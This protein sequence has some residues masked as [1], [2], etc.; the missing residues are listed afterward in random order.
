MSAPLEIVRS[1]IDEKI[2][3]KLRD[4]REVTGTLHA[5]D[6]HCNLVLGD[7]EE[8]VYK[9][10]S[11]HKIETSK[12]TTEMLFVRGDQVIYILLN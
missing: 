7:A 8:T 10:G 9:V 12:N 3:V 2:V 6:E 5:Y 11:E 4:N 1:R